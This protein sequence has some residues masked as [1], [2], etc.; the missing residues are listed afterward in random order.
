M[1]LAHFAV[2]VSFA[3]MSAGSVHAK[4]VRE[5]DL[6]AHIEILA[7]RLKV[8]NPERRARQKRLSI[9]PSNGRDRG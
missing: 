4:A 8:V 1:R 2:F 9:L 6:R 5:A 7:M 3:A